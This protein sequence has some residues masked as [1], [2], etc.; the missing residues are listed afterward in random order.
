MMR[1]IQQVSGHDAK[2]DSA[3]VTK[4]TLTEATYMRAHGACN[5]SA[6][7]AGLNSQCVQYD[8]RALF[9]P[10]LDVRFRGCGLM[11]NLLYSMQQLNHSMTMVPV[12]ASGT[13]AG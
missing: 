10:P 8:I 4:T 2:I 5:P 11:P 1:A 13:D 9:L 3:K 6:E 7:D 12:R